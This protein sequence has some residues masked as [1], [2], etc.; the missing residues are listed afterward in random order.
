MGTG[1]LELV[2]GYGSLPKTCA[3]SKIVE[4]CYLSIQVQ[5]LD[6]D[7]DL[8][9]IIVYQNSSNSTEK[10][11]DKGSLKKLLLLLSASPVR[12]CHSSSTVSISSKP[13]HIPLLYQ[14]QYMHV[15]SHYICKPI[16]RP[17][18]F[19]LAWQLHPLIHPLFSFIIPLSSVSFMHMYS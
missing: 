4:S 7:I 14:L 16:F 5:Q 9:S 19:K 17:F 18:T 3:F 15:F 13:P 11:T 1:L 2:I 12:G 6:N 8:T 10:F